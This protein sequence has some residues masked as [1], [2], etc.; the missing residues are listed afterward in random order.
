MSQNW[1]KL[2]KYSGLYHRPLLTACI[3]GLYQRP[4]CD[5][6][7]RIYNRLAEGIIAQIYF[8]AIIMLIL[9]CFKCIIRFFGTRITSFFNRRYICIRFTGR[10][11][12]LYITCCVYDHHVFSSVPKSLKKICTK[13]SVDYFY[14]FVNINNQPIILKQG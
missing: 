9:Q 11:C 1:V 3:I 4:V 6:R 14:I 2:L 10:A 7:G 13:L 8:K 5:I 12:D